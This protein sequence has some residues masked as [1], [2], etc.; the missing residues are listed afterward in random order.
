MNKMSVAYVLE[1]YTAFVILEYIFVMI[2]TNWLPFIVFGHGPRPFM[3][4]NSGVSLAAKRSKCGDPDLFAR[5]HAH[6]E[7]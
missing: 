1:V 5:L 7:Q 3:Q 4:M 6:T 2:T